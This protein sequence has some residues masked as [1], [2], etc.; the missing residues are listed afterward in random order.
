MDPAGCGWNTAI[1][2]EQ[3]VVAWRCDGCVRWCGQ[4]ESATS[5]SAD[6]ESH[7][8]GVHVN[9]VGDSA[10]PD[11]H[12]AVDGGDATVVDSESLAVGQRARCTGQDWARVA[13]LQVG[14][15]HG[16]PELPHYQRPK[17]ARHNKG[18]ES[19]QA[20]SFDSHQPLAKHSTS[21]CF[22]MQ[23]LQTKPQSTAPSTDA[24]S[25]HTLAQ[26]ANKSA[27]N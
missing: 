24:Q 11:E 16:S 19:K 4:S 25:G 12:G 14:F 2:D 20:I 27:Q 7:G 26:R 22:S 17:S 23:C 5:S 6:N 9:G 3:H 8:T 1:H 21:V 13:C 15:A 10:L 18:L